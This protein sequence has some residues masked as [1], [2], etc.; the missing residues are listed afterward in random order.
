MLF[1]AVTEVNKG[2]TKTIAQKLTANQ[3]YFYYLFLDLLQYIKMRVWNFDPA[4]VFTI[5]ILNAVLYINC[6]LLKNN[7]VAVDNLWKHFSPFTY[8]NFDCYHIS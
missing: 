8:L 2:T 7:I 3:L 4:A 6:C 5:Q 1:G